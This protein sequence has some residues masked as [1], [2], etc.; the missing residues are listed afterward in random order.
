MQLT[1]ELPDGDGLD[2]EEDQRYLAQTPDVPNT[3]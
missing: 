1:I 3:W 2:P